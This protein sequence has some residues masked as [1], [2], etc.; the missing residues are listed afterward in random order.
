M[1]GGSL[2]VTHATGTH[3]KPL[4]LYP[5]PF[6]RARHWDMLEWVLFL[7][8]HDEVTW[9][10]VHGDKDTFRWGARKSSY[11]IAKL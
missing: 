4:Q 11:E 2:S 1:E 5:A 10:M 8:T 6:G 7:N 3:A 9:R